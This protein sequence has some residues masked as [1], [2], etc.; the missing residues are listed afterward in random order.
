MPYSEPDPQ[1]PH[2]L[3]GVEVPAGEEAQVDMAYALAE[4]FIRS[5]FGEQQLI[6]MFQ[7][8]FYRSAHGAFAILGEEKIKSII[9]EVLQVWGR[10][11][12]AD[13]EPHL[14][15]LVELENLTPDQE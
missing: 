15:P 14:E 9:Q 12:L 6:T 10:V 4:E 11:Q 7:N 13:R 8:P 2:S 3:V 5:G 1:D